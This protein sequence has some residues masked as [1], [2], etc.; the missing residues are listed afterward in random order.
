MGKFIRYKQEIWIAL[1]LQEILL[2]QKDSS[3]NT[4]TKI[5]M[6]RDKMDVDSLV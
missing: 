2:D 4:R 3:L 1:K 6:Q 5:F